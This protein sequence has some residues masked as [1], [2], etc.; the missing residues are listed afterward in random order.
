MF[1]KHVRHALDGS[2]TELWRHH[3]SLSLSLYRF[4]FSFFSSYH[5]LF[6]TGQ[7]LSPFCH[8]REANV[9]FGSVRLM[10]HAHVS[11]ECLHTCCIYIYF[12]PWTFLRHVWR[13]P[14]FSFLVSRLCAWR[15]VIF[16]RGSVVPKPRVRG[17]WS[18][19]SVLNRMAFFDV[20]ARR[21]PSRPWF[22]CFSVVFLFRDGF[23]LRIGIDATE[24]IAV[25]YF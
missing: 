25:R 22:S 1:L 12:E 20:G 4:I 14:R 13:I 11:R 5:P 23:D 8:D 3:N 24:S 17:S 9:P 6:V 7:L 10:Y 19:D 2:L 15:N 21:V 16:R 18:C